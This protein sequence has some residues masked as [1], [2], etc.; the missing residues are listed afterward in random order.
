MDERPGDRP[1]AATRNVVDRALGALELLIVCCL[2]RSLRELKE[3]YFEVPEIRDLW[4]SKG[5]RLLCH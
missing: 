2:R 1:E 4:S 3:R 5:K